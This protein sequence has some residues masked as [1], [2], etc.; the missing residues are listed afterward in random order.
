MIEFMKL[1]ITLLFFFGLS[2]TISAQ[3]NPEDRN[4]YLGMQ[5]FGSTSPYSIRSGHEIGK[6]FYFEVSG[7]Y[8]R[9]EEDG[10]DY[11]RVH[12]FIHLGVE[13]ILFTRFT[14]GNGGGIVVGA[15]DAFD[16]SINRLFLRVGYMKM[17]EDRKFFYRISVL[18][19]YKLKESFLYDPQWIPLEIT[20]GITL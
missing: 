11:T 5:I 12:E 19:A 8:F 15:G 20:I 6:D 4:S 9:Y 18:P 3:N 13:L 2:V 1:F 7:G 14:S 17:P 10:S 16:G